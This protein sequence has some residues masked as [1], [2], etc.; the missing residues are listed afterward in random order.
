MQDLRIKINT[1]VENSNVMSQR[2]SQL[3]VLLETSVA[4]Q[5]ALMRQQLQTAPRSAFEIEDVGVG[6]RGDSTTDAE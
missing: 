1:V 2:L 4:Q 5:Q 6:D 3:S